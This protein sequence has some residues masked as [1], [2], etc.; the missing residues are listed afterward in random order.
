MYKDESVSLVLIRTCNMVNT[1][2]IGCLNASVVYLSFVHDDSELK[3]G[4]IWKH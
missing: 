2:F 3:R 1:S 4:S